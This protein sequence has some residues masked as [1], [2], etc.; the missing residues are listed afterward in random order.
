MQAEPSLVAHGLEVVRRKLILGGVRLDLFCVEDPGTWVVIELKRHNA[1]REALMQGIDYAARLAELSID[2]LE[3]V[4]TKD[5]STMSPAARELV[6]RALDRERS[7]EG[8]DIRIVL[9][10]LGTNE[11]LKRMVRYMDGFELPIRIC[12]FSAFTSSSGEGVILSRATEETD[13]ATRAEQG[14]SNTSYDERMAVVIAHQTPWVN[15][16]R[17]NRSSP[18]S[19]RTTAY[20]FDRTSGAS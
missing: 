5:A 16:T 15:E 1:S 20:S 2:E 19:R 10:G 12:S 11:D 3:R 6:T 4:S 18:H 8:R 7:G 14:S 13:E 9:A 17:W